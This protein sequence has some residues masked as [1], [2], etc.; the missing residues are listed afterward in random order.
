M[1]KKICVILPD[2][3]YKKYQKYESKYGS[4]KTKV[5]IMALREFLDKKM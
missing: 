5:V 3:I 4:S 1:P 2:D